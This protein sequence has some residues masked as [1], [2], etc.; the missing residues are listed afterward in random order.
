MSAVGER[1]LI[2]C[3]TDPD[4]LEV[5][6]REG[7][8]MDVIPTEALRPVVEFSI[9]YFFQSGRTKAPSVAVLQTDF[10][11]LLAD[12]EIDIETPAE[13]S[14]EWAI[15]DLKGSY[16]HREFANFNKAQ[17]IAMAEAD[18]AGRIAV[19]ND[20][21][22]ELV[23][24]S[25]ALSSRRRRI[26]MAESLDGLMAN[27]EARTTNLGLTKGLTFGMDIVDNYTLGI[28]EG[29]LAVVAA[30]PKTGKSYF[31]CLVALREWQAGR[32]TVLFTLE[33]SIEMTIDRIACLACEVNGRAWQHGTCSEEEV[34]KVRTWIAEYRN[35]SDML[36]ITQP[37]TDRRSV[38]AMVREAQVF[39]AQSLLIDQLTFID[40]PSPRKPRHERIGEGLHMLHDLI[41]DGRQPM[42]CLLTHQINR[43]GVK[44]A[45]KVGYLE[46]EHMAEAAEVERTADWVFGLFQPH[47]WR[48]THTALLQTL[49][50]RREDNRHFKLNW[51]ITKGEINPMH[52]TTLEGLGG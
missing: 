41:G 2:Q 42:S 25:V 49:G 47:D 45:K 1:T 12:H 7:I 52:I 13:A 44:A 16:V 33:N 48:I 30:P 8:E 43:E 36:Y 15:D 10:G 9:N 28:H 20:A 5:L 22:K 27:Y 31:Q 11:D 29:E 32:R 46:L 39:E 38:E 3:L 50:A 17:A 21:A 6:V 4:D 14:I 51:D 19:L 37:P 34:E 40:L 18:T 35:Y 26:D 24:L 23:R